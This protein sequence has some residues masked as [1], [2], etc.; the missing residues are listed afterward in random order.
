[1]IT[2]PDRTGR[3]FDRFIGQ[4]VGRRYRIERLQRDHGLGPVFVGVDIQTGQGVAIKLLPACS[5]G[6]MKR[7]AARHVAKAMSSIKHQ[8][9][10]Q[11]LCIGQED[12]TPFVVTEATPGETLRSRIHAHGP[13]SAADAVA[14]MSQVLEALT[15]AHQKGLI[16]RNVKPENILLVTS[17]G[18]PPSIKVLDLGIAQ[19]H[20]SAA[21]GTHSTAIGTPPYLSPEQLA[22][23]S[24]LDGRVDIWAAGL[25]LHEAMTGIRAYDGRSLQ[26]VSRRVGFQ[27]APSI[28]VAAI[29]DVLRRA[30][31]KRRDDRFRT[32]DEFRDALLD[33]CVDAWQAW[34]DSSG[35]RVKF[36]PATT[37]GIHRCTDSSDEEEDTDLHLRIDVEL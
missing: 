17:A 15:V 27:H 5:A 3:S 24:D 6:A 12:S 32:A 21:R 22:G 25:T 26:E 18:Q 35:V 13:L 1:V 10:A 20:S 16:H 34:H 36:A 37:N 14:M 23:M 30:I 8:Y 28:G 19:L 4:V 31:A 29:D 7:K 2:P 33:A 11:V 9:I